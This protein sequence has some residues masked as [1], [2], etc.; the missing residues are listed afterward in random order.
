MMEA[1]REYAEG[2][3]YGFTHPASTLLDFTIHTVVSTV[4]WARSLLPID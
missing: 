1:L 4:S 2:F 3:A